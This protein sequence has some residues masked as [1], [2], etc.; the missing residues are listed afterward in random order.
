MKRALLQCSERVVGSRSKNE[1][2]SG[3]DANGKGGAGKR[4]TA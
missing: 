1:E 4:G 3:P 2:P